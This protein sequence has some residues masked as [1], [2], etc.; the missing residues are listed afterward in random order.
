M[1]REACFL[2]ESIDSPEIAITLRNAAVNVITF[3]ER[4]ARGAE[5]EVW[6]G[7]VRDRGWLLFTRD[8]GWHRNRAE[9]LSIIS[10]RA[11]AFIF[12]SQ[13]SAADIAHLIWATLPRIAAIADENSPPAP[14][15]YK[16]SPRRVIEIIYPSAK[17]RF[18]LR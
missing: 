14:Y 5:D 13:G 8:T 12:A 9:L 18:P 6:L 1:P 2:D 16:V 15:I 7:Q 10:A 11:R 3:T 17:F 4:F